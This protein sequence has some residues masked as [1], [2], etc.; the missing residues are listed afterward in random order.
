MIQIAE[1]HVIDMLALW[2]EPKAAGGESFIQMP[3]NFVID[4]RSHV[5]NLP[6]RRGLSI[7]V[8]IL[9]RN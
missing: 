8:I 3:G 4:L 1:E 5:G 9:S 7:F 6:Q 2:S